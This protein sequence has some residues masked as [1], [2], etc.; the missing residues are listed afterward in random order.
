[1]TLEV[2]AALKNQS[3]GPTHQNMTI[4]FPPGNFQITPIHMDTNMAQTSPRSVLGI[5]LPPK[6]PR[7]IALMP[8][9]HAHVH[10]YRFSKDA[11]IAAPFAAI[12]IVGVFVLPEVIVGITDASMTRNP[13]IP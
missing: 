13:P 4:R 8:M 5:Y 7:P 12:I 3:M 2:K 10:L 9:D 6:K 11:I 1:M